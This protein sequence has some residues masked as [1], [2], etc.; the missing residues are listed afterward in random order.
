MFVGADAYIGP[1][2]SCE[3]AGDSRKIGIFCGRTEASA[4]TEYGGA[5]KPCCRGRRLCRPVWVV[6]NSPKSSV[7]TDCSARADVGIGP[8]NQMRTYLRIRR[9]FPK[10]RCVLPGGAAPPL[11]ELCV[12]NHNHRP[13]RWFAQAPL[14]PITS[15]TYRF[16]ESSFYCMMRPTAIEIAAWRILLFVSPW[17]SVF[18]NHTLSPAFQTCSSLRSDIFSG[19]S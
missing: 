2:G 4:P 16:I 6:T 13:C 7:K 17:L 10:I 8:Y 1:L 18:L 11:P 14:G 15:R 12:C 9:R 5:A 19:H 3:I